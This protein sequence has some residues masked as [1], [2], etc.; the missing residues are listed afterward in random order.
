MPSPT[1]RY[2]IREVSSGR[3]AVRGFDSNWL[4]RSTFYWLKGNFACDCNR[5]L[6]FDRGLGAVGTAD[7]YPCNVKTNAYVFDWVELD[8]VRFIED[9]TPTEHASE[10]VPDA[11]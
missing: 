3:T 7:S 10:D 9:D 5:K 6:E 4:G 11:Y 2:Q 8:G 1:Y